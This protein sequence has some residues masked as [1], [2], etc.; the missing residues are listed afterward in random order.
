LL[1]L[2]H[3]SLS[4]PRLLHSLPEDPYAYPKFRVA[5]LNAPVMNE[6]AQRWFAQG[7]RGGQSEF[8]DHPSSVRKEIGGGTDAVQNH[9]DNPSLEPLPITTANYTLEHMKLG[10]RDSYICLIPEPP[11]ISPPTTEDVS[12][13]EV[14]PAR[15]WSLLHPLDGTCLY[16]CLFCFCFFLL[17]SI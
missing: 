7:L 10:P 1:L 14:S 9:D 8:L 13:S 16:V 15:S 17:S 3:A 6:T 11:D 2:L 12:D 4:S 5:F